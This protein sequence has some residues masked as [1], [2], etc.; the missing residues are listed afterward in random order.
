MRIFLA[1]STGAIGRLLLPR[2]LNSGHHVIATTQSTAKVD[3]LRAT[4]AEPV[5]LDALDRNATIPA[6]VD[7]RPDVV[8]HQLTA[9]SGRF[10]LKNFDR[11]LTRT[12]RLRK[13]GTDNLLE[14]ARQSGAKRFIAQSFTGWPNP[15]S[16]GRIKSESDGLDPDPLSEMS[17]TLAAINH[18]ENAVSG[19]TGLQGVVLRYGS[20]YGPGTSLAADGDLTNMI[21]QHKFPLVGNGAGVWSFL[22]IDDAVHATHMSVEAKSTQ[23]IYNIV[24]DEPV[25][26]ST[27]LPELARMLQAKAPLHIPVWIARFLIGNAGVAM[28]TTI[29][30]SSNTLA[31]QKLKWEPKFA[32]WRQGFH[33][34]L[35]R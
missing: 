20:F 25:E 14:G 17:Q 30:G 10:D 4:G 27:W 7:A 13:S 5:V 8:V 34:E 12:N 32:N 23:G 29:R 6:V 26:V 33:Y 22:H 18:L 11:T 9:L 21:R 24:D 15:R 35:S 19:A 28:M 16:G 31:K 3:G 2:L 1:G